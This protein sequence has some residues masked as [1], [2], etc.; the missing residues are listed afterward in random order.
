MTLDPMA[1]LFARLAA[2]LLLLVVTFLV[3]QQGRADGAAAER[4]TAHVAAAKAAERQAALIAEADRKS[5][6]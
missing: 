6:V 3:Y 4:V 1:A 5:V 2:P